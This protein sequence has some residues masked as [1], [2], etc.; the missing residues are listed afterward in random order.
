M[1]GLHR[2]TPDFWGFFRIFVPVKLVEDAIS[3]LNSNDVFTIPHLFFSCILP[4]PEPHKKS[5]VTADV[6]T[7]FNAVFSVVVVKF[8]GFLL[9]ASIHDTAFI[10]EVSKPVIAFPIGSDCI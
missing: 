10:D 1:T 4:V 6:F 8:T 5:E 3:Q 7:I 9:I 2:H